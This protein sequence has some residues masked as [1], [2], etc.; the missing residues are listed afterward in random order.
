MQREENS[1][2]KQTLVMQSKGGS[3]EIQLTSN[4]QHPRNDD[5]ARF[6][7]ERNTYDD[8]IALHNAMH[9]HFPGECTLVSIPT[10]FCT[11]KLE[12]SSFNSTSMYSFISSVFVFRDTMD[13]ISLHLR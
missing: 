12:S 2:E 9:Y 7:V 1:V 4:D 11:N 10:L 3:N 8:P 6:V 5:F 13:S